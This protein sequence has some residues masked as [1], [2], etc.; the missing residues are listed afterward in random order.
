[1]KIPKQWYYFIKV[2]KKRY[3]SEIVAD[4]IRVFQNEKAIEECYTTYEF[5][6][7]LPNYFPIADD[8][9]GQVAV[10]T[11]D[12]NNTKVYQTSYGTL[13]EEDM[14]VLASNLQ[15]WMEANFPFSN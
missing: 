15:D 4:N 2:F 12:E 8:S 5:E 14:E 10:I 6:E 11:T 3:Q 1:M 7:Y 9:G 13:M